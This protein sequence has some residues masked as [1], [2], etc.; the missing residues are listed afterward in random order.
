MFSFSVFML[1]LTMGYGQGDYTQ[2]KN[3]GI[4]SG[5]A[6]VAKP[7]ARVEGFRSVT[8]EP[9]PEKTIWDTV[10]ETTD[11]WMGGGNMMNS[12]RSDAGKSELE[13]LNSRTKRQREMSVLTSM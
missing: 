11:A 4:F 12:G 6:K 3:W 2:P 10:R 1:L 8:A 7:G 5:Q 13:K 9:V